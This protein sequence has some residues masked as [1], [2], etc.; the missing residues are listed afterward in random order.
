M[1]HFFFNQFAKNEFEALQISVHT[2][3]IIFCHKIQAKFKEGSL[4]GKKSRL[5]K[6]QLHVLYSFVSIKLA[7]IGG[8]A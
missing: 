3:E 6:V 2:I 1:L 4:T 7:K 8:N 5:K